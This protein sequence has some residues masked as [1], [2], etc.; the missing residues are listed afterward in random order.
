MNPLPFFLQQREVLRELFL[1]L[2]AVRVLRERLQRLRHELE[3][4][5]KVSVLNANSAWL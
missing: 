5:L 3:A 2:Q 1:Q 4:L